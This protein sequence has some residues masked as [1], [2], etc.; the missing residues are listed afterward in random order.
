MLMYFWWEGNEQY[1]LS[2]FQ[3]LQDGFGFAYTM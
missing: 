3:Y 1:I 2:V